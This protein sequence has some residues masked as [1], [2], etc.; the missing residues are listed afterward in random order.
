MCNDFNNFPKC[1]YDGGDCSFEEFS[2]MTSNEG[3][4]NCEIG[5]VFGANQ[6]GD[7][8]YHLCLSYI[9]QPR[10]ACLN[11]IIHSCVGIR[12]HFNHVFQEFVME[13]NTIPQNVDLTMA[14]VSN[15]I[16]NTHVA[17]L[18]F[19]NLLEMVSEY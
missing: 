18:N 1:D 17:R 3:Y 10:A 5:G 8:E 11:F 12:C 7:G 14:I 2:N 16:K 4:P 6:L 13:V 9:F 19:Q 15:S